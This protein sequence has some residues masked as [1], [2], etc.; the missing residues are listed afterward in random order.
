M[1]IFTT[2][3]AVAGGAKVLTGLAGARNRAQG[4]LDS[5]RDTL[6][7]A[8]SNINQRKLEAQQSQFQILETGHQAAS[9]VQ[10][11]A[12]K[13]EGSARA[14]AG[15]SGVVLD[16]GTPQQVLSNIAQEG[17]VAQKDVI[18]NA[19]NQ[20][21]AV[22]R[23]TDNMNKSEWHEAQDYKKRMSEEAK[24]TIDNSRMQAVAD[25]AET[26][27]SVYSA[28]TAGGTKAFSWGLEGA[29]TAQTVKSLKSQPGPHAKVT[30][31]SDVSKGTGRMPGST[32]Y[33]SKPKITGKGITA[34]K[35]YA[36]RPY[37]EA[38][39]YTKTYGLFDRLTHQ[40]KTRPFSFTK[41]GF[42]GMFD[43]FRASSAWPFVTGQ[44]LKGRAASKKFKY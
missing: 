34:K 24:Q 31:Y 2:A 22:R 21:K 15:S 3:L 43:P 4:M 7:T 9:I 40:A 30:P 23:D 17:L 5:G 42:S 20:M 8:R 41:K 32:K 44:G 38:G 1:A 28:G 13:A 16:G 33:K 37:R 11:E 6:L 14:T 26:A 12:T 19:R 39:K 27:L 29:K 35:G 36:R 10:R 18:L 25:I